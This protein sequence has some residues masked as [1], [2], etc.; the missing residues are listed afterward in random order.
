MGR[1]SPDRRLRREPRHACDDGAR[2]RR[3]SRHARRGQRSGV[4]RARDAVL[5]L[6]D[7]QQ[8][9][10]AAR[11]LEPPAAAVTARAATLLAACRSAEVPVVHVHTTVSRADDR[12]MAHWKAAGRWMCEQGT[13][14]H[15]PPA[16]LSPRAGERVVEKRGFAAPAEQLGE[17]LGGTR[18]VIVAGVH[19]HACVRQVVLD[20]YERDAMVWVAE[21]ATASHD[22]MHAAAARNWLARR[23]ARFMPD[24]QIVAELGGPPPVSPGASGAGAAVAR[25]VSAGHEWRKVPPSGRADLLTRLAARLE[26][27][28]EP[29]AIQIAR[30]LGKPVRHGRTEVSRTVEMLRAVARRAPGP[31]PR[32]AR[33]IAEVRD[34]AHGVVAVVTPW[35]NPLYIPLGKIAPALLHGNSAVWKPAP[36]ASGISGRA[37]ELLGAAGLPPG[38]VELVHGDAE[39]ARELM[40]H[41]DVA[42][43][44]LTG[45]AAAGW[46]AREICA[47]RHVP[48]QAELGGNNAALVWPEADL[49]HAAR[50][51]ASGAFAQAGQRCTA[52]RRVIVARDALE[53]LV[54]LLERAT[55]AMAIGDPLDDRTEIGPLV[56]AGARDRVAH[57]IERAGDLPRVVP[58]DGPLPTGHFLA[59]TIIRCEDSDH[60]VVRHETFGP[61]LVV[62]PAENFDHALALLNGV[63]HGLAAALFCDSPE[64][65]ER[66]LAEADAG[67]LKLGRSTADA[68]VD[69]PFGGWKA[70][71]LGPPEHGEFDRLFYVRP[72]TVYR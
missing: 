36:A 12:R 43:V 22:P 39:E 4:S 13:P 17:A 26:S 6:V 28:V 71:G 63:S 49:E 8:D 65:T 68:A 24:G 15:E 38:L 16:E 62:Q 46:A 32:E 61:L 18:R 30:E 60:E 31:D 64:L 48:L 53:E 55:A 58:H 1:R 10:L 54:A 14:G 56:D 9:Y 11:E 47:R 40:G 21:D 50:E 20:A 41:P 29:L 33:A 35:N 37:L 2:G 44:T 66:F 5:V 52:N 23:V 3:R 45:S 69:V 67:I 42:A 19:L 59:P 72:Q 34:R 57:V 27:E 51:I 25:A 70:S 7:L